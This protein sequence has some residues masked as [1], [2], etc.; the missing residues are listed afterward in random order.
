MIKIAYH[1]IY[2][3]SL[4]EGHRFPMEKY[5]LIPSQ[6]LRDGL[7]TDENL[8]RPNLCNRD[9]ILMTH[10]LGY[11]EKI[12]QQL[13]STSE[14][15]RIGFP[16]SQELTKREFII[17]QGTIDCCFFAL[18]NGVAINS[19]GGTH[20][21]FADRGEAYCL[22]NDVAIASNYLLSLGTVGKILVIDL[23][24]HQGNGTAKIFENNSNVF[25]FSL[26]GANTY[27]LKK[28]K[29]DLDISLVDGIEDQAYMA[30]LEE[31]LTRVIDAFKP[32]FAFYISGVDVLETDQLGRLKI[33]LEG[34]K[35]RDEFVFQQ[36]NSNSI[37]VTVVM[38]GGYSPYIKTILE[39]HCNTYK[40]AMLIYG[41]D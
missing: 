10:E 4:P 35:K 32:D 17:V 24:V 3:H 41:Q 9:I 18:V 36:L 20:H 14:Q 2:A 37:P 22:L 1:P 7:I 31:N 15:R 11:L 25:T 26:H 8:F 16:Q 5:T 34:C 19:A 12:E 40:A 39:A 13:L 28:E 38:G 29:S 21:A 6:L 23:D 30:L 27:P 33:T